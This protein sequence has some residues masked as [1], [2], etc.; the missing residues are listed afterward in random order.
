ST[1]MNILGCLDYATEGSYTI[2][3]RETRDLEDH[4]LAELR[5]DHFGFIFQR[6]HLLPHLSAMH[7]VEMPS[8]YAGVTEAQRH[9]RAKELL[10]RL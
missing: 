9:S 10:A 8:I 2:N 4:E 7:N 6:Y 3:G 1:L 5:R